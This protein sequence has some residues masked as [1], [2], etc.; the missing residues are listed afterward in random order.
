[1]L[2]TLKPFLSLRTL[3]FLFV[4]C[5]SESLWGQ[6]GSN[7]IWYKQVPDPNNPPYWYHEDWGVLFNY[8]KPAEKSVIDT[9]LQGMYNAGQRRLRIPIFHSRVAYTGAPLQWATV[10]NSAGGMLSATHEAN[11]RNFL[12]KLRQIG[13]VQVEIGFFPHGNNDPTGWPAWSEDYF[14]ENWGLISNLHPILE[15][16]VATTGLSYYI[17]LMNEAVFPSPNDIFRSEY[18]PGPDG[19]LAYQ[20][21]VVQCSI[22]QQY[23]WSLWTNYVLVFGKNDTVGFSI[24][25]DGWDKKIRNFRNI[26][27]QCPGPYC[28]GPYVLSAHIY[29]Q[30]GSDERYRFVGLHN[31]LNANGYPKENT[32]IIIGEAYYNDP[33]AAAN[34]RAAVTETGRTIF[35]VLQWPVYRSGAIPDPLPTT[36]FGEYLSRG[37]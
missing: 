33:V 11:L 21:A 26:Y 24:N 4:L 37:F 35:H 10:L 34:F 22:M 3:V 36:Q 9:Q 6:G 18:P 8:H 32:G 1:M 20:A 27:G 12:T 5:I 23:C 15:E 14:Q 17:D 16:M 28:N 2:N 7:Y 19:D 29:S 30:P 13:F 31:A 25:V